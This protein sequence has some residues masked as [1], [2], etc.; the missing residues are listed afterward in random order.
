MRQW[1]FVLLSLAPSFTW[2][3]SCPSWFKTHSEAQAIHAWLTRFKN[4]EELH[5]CKIE[6]EVC[7]VGSEEADDAPI[8]EVLIVTPDNREAYL[9]IDFAEHESYWFK[10]K[11]KQ[12]KRSIVYTKRDRYYEPI[13]GRT[14]F[15]QLEFQ[16]EWD[17]TQLLKNVELGIYTTHSQLNQPNGNDSHWFVCKDQKK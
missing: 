11:V 4:I 12:H 14:E 16:T 6:I 7:D 15:W 3:Y 1:I 10:T 2:G 8:G 5:G 17:D 9:S 13:N